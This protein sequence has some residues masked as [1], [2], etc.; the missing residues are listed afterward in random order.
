[1]HSLMSAAEKRYLVRFLPAVI[2]H[3]GMLFASVWS[4]RHLEL[5]GP[6]VWALALAPALPLLAAIAVTGLYVIEET[7]EFLRAMLVQ[8]MLWGIGLTLA[9]CTV[10]G[11]LENA[12]LIPHLPLY[13]V[14]SMFCVAMG[15]A[16]PVVRWKYR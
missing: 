12:H 9:V 16:Q 13:L 3:V 8:A 1:M 2:V 5:Q 6:L 11:A 10:W 14:F 15:L 7:D 4:I